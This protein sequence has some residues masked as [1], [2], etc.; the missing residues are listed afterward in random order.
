L[1]ILLFDIGF[2]KIDAGWAV[3]EGAG[4]SEFASGPRHDRAW[5]SSGNILGALL[6]LP[7]S[8]F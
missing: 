8:A 7:I 5:V 1:G 4:T 2:G 6:M 3:Y